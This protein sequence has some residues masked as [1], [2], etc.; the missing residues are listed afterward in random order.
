MARAFG[1]PVRRMLLYPLGGL[2]RDRA[3]AAD[4]GPGVPGLR[5]RAGH[6]AGRSPA[7]GDSA[8]TRSCSAACGD[9]RVLIDQLYPGQPAW[10]GCSTCCRACRWTAA[11]SCAPRCGSSPASRRA[12]TIRRLGGP[13]AGGRAGRGGRWQPAGLGVGLAER[14]YW[15]WLVVI[16]RVHVD[17]RRA[18]HPVGQG[19]RAAARAA[20]A[21]RWPG[22][23][24]RSRGTSRWPRRSGAPTWRRRARWSSST[25]SPSRSRSSTRAR[26]S[27]RPSS[28]GRGS[29]LA[30]SRG[31][32]SPGWCCPRTCPAWTLIEAVQRAPATRV[33]AGRASGQ[34]YGVLADRRS[35]PRLRRGLTADRR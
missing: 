8:L 13:G 19:A 34:V 10:S 33:P 23:R 3:G 5:R 22:G 21:Q 32:S 29:R 25:T 20:G 15:L 2:L 1:L 12:T 7:C 16:A 6:V 9:T 11:G 17:E 18:G 14:P 28:A 4:A 26:S 31:P 27:P 24:S 30:R 35:R